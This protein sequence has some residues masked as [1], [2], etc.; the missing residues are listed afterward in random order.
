MAATRI[1]LI[2][3]GAIGRELAKR[4]AEGAAPGHALI[5]VLARDEGEGS[6]PPAPLYCATLAALLARKPDL[7]IEAASTE[8][9]AEFGPAVLAARIDLMLLSVAGLAD[10]K[11][12]QA[13]AEAAALSPARAYVPSGAIAGLDAISAAATSGLDSVTLVQRKP[14]RGLLAPEE[15]AALAGERILYEG[16]ARE[17]ALRFPRNSNIAAALGLAGIGLDRTQVRVVADSRVSRNTVELSARGAFGELDITLANVPSDNPKTSRLT[18]MSVL[19][20][21]ARR[22]AKLVCP[23]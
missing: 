4:L 2:G 5:G 23:G 17:A 7:V 20:C 11:L 15:A 19:A 10:R 13:L 3:Y 9:L 6:L 21:L 18:A 8:A 12:E 1:G 22:S 14:P 16:S